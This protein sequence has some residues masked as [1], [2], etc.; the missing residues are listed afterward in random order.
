MK[1]S[2]EEFETLQD[3]LDALINEKSEDPR[4]STR[5]QNKLLKRVREAEDA[6]IAI[7]TY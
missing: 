6:L 7:G 1:L 5:E 4:V 2:S 3:G